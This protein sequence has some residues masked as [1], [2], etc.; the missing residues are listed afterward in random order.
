LVDLQEK[1]PKKLTKI[2]KIE[3]QQYLLFATIST[4]ES[5]Y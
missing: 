4:K 1:L 2:K 3:Q 5:A